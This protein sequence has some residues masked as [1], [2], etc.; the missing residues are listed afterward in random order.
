MSNQELVTQSPPAAPTPFNSSRALGAAANAGAVAIEQE[1]AIAEAQGQLVLAK[2]FPRDLNSAHAELMTACKSKAF[3]ATAFY[4][5]PQGGGVV[6]G[7]SIRMLEEVA[8]VYG[9]LQYGA[10]ELSRDDKKSEV[11]IFVWDMEKNTYLKRQKTVMHTRDTKDG[12]KKLRDQTDVDQKINNVASKEVRGLLQAVVA[13][14]LLADAIEECKKT[15][16]G[17]NDEPLEARVRRMAQAFAKY[18]VT[19]QHLEKYLGHGLA[20]TML[21]ELVEMQ[22]IF[23]A[24]KE[25]TPASELFG[26]EEQKDAEA[27]ASAS[28]ANKLAETAKAGAAAKPRTPRSAATPQQPQQQAEPAQEKGSPEAE[29]PASAENKSADA[30]KVS[31]AVEETNQPDPDVSASEPPADADDLF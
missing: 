29:K 14:W 22:G 21:D 19:A 2:K 10:R 5:K 9:N 15:I 16:A 31:K 25:G 30:P 27:D 23:N 20:E 1:R 12:P 8:R 11:E 3:A 26:D 7:P 13:K 6:S 17:N 18:G 4:S 28:T 24:L